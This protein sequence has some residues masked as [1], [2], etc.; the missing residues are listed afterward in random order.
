MPDIEES[1]VE[2]KVLFSHDLTPTSVSPAI[3]GTL[4]L[5]EHLYN[6][7]FPTFWYGVA[8]LACSLKEIQPIHEGQQEGVR[9]IVILEDGRK[10]LARYTAGHLSKEGP[11]ET[12]CF[13]LVGVT[14]LGPK[15]PNSN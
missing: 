5:F 15:K 10:G 4:H 7:H 1:K 3:A 2:C 14:S 13:A 12:W 11:A 8:E 6:R 9:A